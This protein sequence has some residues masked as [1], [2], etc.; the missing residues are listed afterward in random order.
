MIN[1]GILPLT[2]QNEADYDKIEQGDTLS[3]PDVRKAVAAG[4]PIIV[5]N[6]TKGIEIP[7]DCDLSGRS[8]DILLSGGLLSY[9]KDQLK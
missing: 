4:L 7:V 2:F 6:V 5:K 9:T 8:K 3:L 1:A